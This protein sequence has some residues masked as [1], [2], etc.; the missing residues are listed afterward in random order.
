MVELP[1]NEDYVKEVCGENPEYSIIKVYLPI[2]KDGIF[3]F[4]LE[5]RLIEMG[6]NFKIPVPKEYL[7]CNLETGK[8]IKTYQIKTEPKGRLGKIPIVKDMF[9]N[10]TEIV[11]VVGK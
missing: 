10:Y 1:L 11:L 4:E 7:T 8:K 3:E 2:F 6:I 9:S 5:S